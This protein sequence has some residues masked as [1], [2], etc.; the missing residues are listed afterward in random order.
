M[1]SL[2]QFITCA[3]IIAFSLWLFWINWR[4]DK[5]A[6]EIDNGCCHNCGYDLRYSKKRCPE[7]GV[8]ILRRSGDHFPLRDDWPATPIKPRMP[9][10]QETPIVVRSTS[11]RDEARLIQEQLNAR[12]IACWID[13]SKTSRVVGYASTQVGDPHVMVWSEDEAAA[14][15]LLD[16]LM[17]HRERVDT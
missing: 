13:L 8:P 11:I 9:S 6:S 7:C 10:P 12:G 3:A 2:G 4:R 5:I 17:Q 15:E 14:K 16:R 1:Q